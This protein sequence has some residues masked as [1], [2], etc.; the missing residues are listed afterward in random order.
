MT[1]IEIK[2]AIDEVMVPEIYAK[3]RYDPF[4]MLSLIVEKFNYVCIDKFRLEYL[5]INDEGEF[6]GDI[7]YPPIINRIF[8]NGFV[9]KL[10]RV[11]S[12]SEKQNCEKQNCEKIKSPL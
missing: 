5:H 7:D 2:T 8:K 11:R 6:D 1:D 9:K 3:Y 4:G 12:K 10:Q